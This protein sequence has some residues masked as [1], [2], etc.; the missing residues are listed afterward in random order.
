[1]KKLLCLGTA[2]GACALG[3]AAVGMV[4]ASASGTAALGAGVRADQEFDVDIVHSTLNFRLRH[5][6]VAYFYGRI[7]RPEGVFLLNSA[8]PA[9][10][11]VTITAELAKMDAGDENRN[12]FL[13]SPDFFNGREYPTAE[14]RS[15][16][17]KKTDDT[18]WE[19]AGNFAL[20]GVTKPITVRLT[21]Y[22]E[23]KSAIPKFG[24]RAGFLC[25]F[26]IKRSD[27][28]VDMYA[29][30][31]TLGDEVQITAAIEGA[32]E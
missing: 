32:H 23:T 29:K 24:Y 6:N 3:L 18:T 2:L 15:T 31:G 4:I 22:A 26:T 16:S 30:D 1:M 9:K 20:H 14:F 13:L 28:G 7:N 25:V 5:F 12:K 21:E 10:S 17:V 19:A 11:H 8:D 27:F